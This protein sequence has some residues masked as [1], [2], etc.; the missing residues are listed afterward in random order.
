MI[1]NVNSK[2][3]YCSSSGKCTSGECKVVDKNDFQ[4]QSLK[5]KG[6]VGFGRHHGFVSRCHLSGWSNLFCYSSRLTLALRCCF[7]RSSS[8]VSIAVCIF[9]T[10]RT[11]C[12]SL[13]LQ[14]VQSCQPTSS[15]LLKMLTKFLQM[16]LLSNLVDRSAFCLS[17]STAF[18]VKCI[19][20][21]LVMNVPLFIECSF[22]KFTFRFLSDVCAL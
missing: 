12:T 13:A 3:V 2:I 20:C 11:H 15:K 8:L 22:A 1:S 5:E 21:F 4:V 6:L 14:S 16:I 17:V 19:D 9:T 10:V 18:T 7:A